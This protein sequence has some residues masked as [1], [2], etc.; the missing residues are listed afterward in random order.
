MKR[1]LTLGLALV[2]VFALSA[3]IACTPEAEEPEVAN[4]EPEVTTEAPA[5]ETLTPGYLTIATGNPAFPPWVEDDDPESGR[6]FEAAV[7]YAVAERLGFAPEQVVWVRTDFEAAIAPGPKDFDFNLQ[8]FS[9]NDERREVVDFSSSYF[10]SPQAVLTLTDSEFAD[11]GSIAD[12]QGATIGAAAGSTSLLIA[13]D[14]FEDV[15]IFNDV[16]AAVQALSVGQIDAIINDLPSVLFTA[17]VQLY[18][19]GGGAL[20]GTIEGS[21][22]G[23]G[24]GLLLAK[25]SPLTAPVTEAVD[26]LRADG[27]LDRLAEEWLI[28][29]AGG[30]ILR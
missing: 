1:F 28:A 5:L 24:F 7:A 19:V 10:V 21:D 11:A 3:L 27:T 17:A 16:A 25:D 22:E 30:V 20:V 12:L 29:G 9:I 26:S 15:A 6:G 2:L 4:D 23:E 13:E 14:H 8:Q 18:D